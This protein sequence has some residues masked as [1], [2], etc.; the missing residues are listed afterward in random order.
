MSVWAA[1]VFA[2]SEISSQAA[3]EYRLSEA[4]FQAVIAKECSVEELSTDE[5][6]DTE[7]RLQSRMSGNPEPEELVGLGC[8]RT[9]LYRRRVVAKSGAF[10]SSGDSWY[11]GAIRALLQVVRL[12]PEPSLSGK[13]WPIGGAGNLLGA[14]LLADNRA[15]GWDEVSGELSLIANRSGRPPMALRACSDLAFAA[16]VIDASESCTRAALMNGI[17]STAQLIRMSRLAA[18]R[19]DTINSIRWLD[20]A[21]TSASGTGE[22]DEIGWHLTWLLTPEEHALWEDG[23]ENRATF[24][25]E[26]LVR[27]DVRDGQTLGHRWMSHLSRLE[28]VE[29]RYRLPIGR[30]DLARF[31]VAAVPESEV[32]PEKVGAYWEPGVVA[33]RPFR[34]SQ[35]THPEYDDRAHVFMRYGSPARRIAWSQQ[36]TVSWDPRDSRLRLRSVNTRE[37]WLIQLPAGQLLL[38][39]EAERFD[40][41]T[42]ATRLVAGVLGTYLCDLDS[43]RCGLSMRASTGASPVPAEQVEQLYTQDRGMI[44]TATEDD[45]SGVVPLRPLTV[46]GNAYALW[47]PSSGSRILVAAYGVKM[48]DLET[49]T[50]AGVE[51]VSITVLFDRWLDSQSRVLKDT[52]ARRL[53]LPSKVDDDAYITGHLVVDAPSS[54]SVVWG[55]QISQSD[56]ARGRVSGTISGFDTTPIQLSDVILGSE[57]QQEVAQVGSDR[58]LLGPLG[59]FPRDEPLGI[60]WQVKSAVE[61]DSVAIGI[62]ILKDGT[63]TPE[64]AIT[65][66]QVLYLGIT[67]FERRLDVSR[68]SP[69]QYYLLLRVK[70]T[71]ETGSVTRRARLIIY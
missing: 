48:K 22:W 10:M 27:R 23:L 32:I 64:I 30:Y 63:T 15:P 49:F 50:E 3:G 26:V 25:R 54:N 12:S 4:A 13:Q 44:A 9:E 53:R 57:S 67:G 16:G 46:V 68:L 19:Q 60:Y 56:S 28:V 14:L 62:E 31:E 29:D 40:G 71:S 21:L 55:L 5:L 35:R 52:V 2:V 33:A 42:E 37:A 65:A 39:F 47:N 51:G 59:A 70:G 17:D 45:Y 7:R 1:V 41:S 43:R 36:D 18:I 38:S 6:L 61:Q 24:A 8:L 34:E 66:K 20:S 11:L 69:G 58:I